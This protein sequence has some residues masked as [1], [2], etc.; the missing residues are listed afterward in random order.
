[1]RQCWLL[2]LVTGL[3]F[4]WAGAA[5]AGPAEKCEAAKHK[6]TGKLAACLAKAAARTAVGGPGHPGACGFKMEQAFTK[7]EDKA[8]GACPTSND[9]YGI[10][11]TIDSALTEHGVAARLEGGVRFVDNGDG[12]VTDLAT[13]LIWEKKEGMDGVA[14]YLN[15]H[16][17]DNVYSWVGSGTSAN[18]TAYTDFL[19]RLNDDDGAGCFIGQCDWR[20]PTMN[21]I[22]AIADVNVVGCD[23]GAPCIFPVFGPTKVGDYWSTTRDLA[24]LPSVAVEDTSIGRL[25][26][27]FA[28]GV[29]TYVRAVRGNL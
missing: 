7:A 18:G 27:I 12:T 10:M 24:N 11:L 22:Q 28:P 1:M 8:A 20:L 23:A 13:Q 5:A 15:A 19:D 29:S 17:A 21:E 9:G 4:M 26:F 16:D 25:T 6:A 14:N 3:G 2:V